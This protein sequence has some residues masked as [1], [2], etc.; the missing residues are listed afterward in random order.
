MKSSKILA[1]LRPTSAEEVISL[2]AK[3]CQF[4]GLV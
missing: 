2:A 3:S 4:I 1:L